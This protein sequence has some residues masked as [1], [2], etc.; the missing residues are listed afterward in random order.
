MTTSGVVDFFPDTG[1][2]KISEY[3]E[4]PKDFGLDAGR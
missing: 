3:I 1:G 2:R 4:P